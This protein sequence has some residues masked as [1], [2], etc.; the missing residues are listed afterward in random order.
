VFCRCS[1][2]SSALSV[3]LGFDPRSVPLF[4]AISSLLCLESLHPEAHH[5]LC[6]DWGS[7]LEWVLLC[8]GQGFLQNILLLSARH[9]TAF[10]SYG[11]LW[12]SLWLVAWRKT[13]GSRP[14]WNHSPT[15][16]F[17]LQGA[18]NRYE[19]LLGLARCS[20]R[21][22][23]TCRPNCR[24]LTSRWDEQMSPIILVQCEVLY[25]ATS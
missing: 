20:H 14:N 6:S 11:C 15:R 12:S 16:R 21:V 4:F 25:I 8:L 10:F 13:L 2:S 3:R 23:C 5:R 22:L 24:T 19:T 18:A 1:G 7:I 17:S 9:H